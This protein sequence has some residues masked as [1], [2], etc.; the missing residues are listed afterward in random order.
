MLRE[1]RPFPAFP[2]VISL[3]GLIFCLWVL[4]SGGE[5]L[6]V[7][8]GCSLFQDF[9]LAGVSLWQAGTALFVLL[10]L[11]TALRGLRIGLILAHIALAADLLLLGVMLFTAPCAN[12]LIVGLLIAASFFSFHREVIPQRRVRR[13]PLLLLWTLLLAACSMALL[14][15]KRK[16]A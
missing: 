14:R 7:T 15:F 8:N 10:L 12:C 2:A 9:R 4:L 13:S 16:A 11:L 6:C 1:K 3:A 5:S